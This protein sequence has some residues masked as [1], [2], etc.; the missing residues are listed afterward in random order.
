VVAVCNALNKDECTAVADSWKKTIELNQLVFRSNRIYSH[1]SL[2]KIPDLGYR[3]VLTYTDRV[4]DGPDFISSYHEA[5][6]TGLC[7]RELWSE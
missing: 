5:G 4:E 1:S 6:L 7:F 2:F 3:P